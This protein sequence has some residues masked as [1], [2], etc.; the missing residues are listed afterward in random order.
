VPDVELLDFRDRRYRAEICCGQAMSGVNRELKLGGEPSSVP[1]GRSGRDVVRMIR[2][3]S[4]MEFDRVG[5]HLARKADRF[6]IWA[7]E[8]AGSD[9]GFA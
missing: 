8:Q 6:Q 3:Y 7:N 9:A 4:G 5:A 2:E 1:E